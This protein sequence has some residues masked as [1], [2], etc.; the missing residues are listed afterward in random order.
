[1]TQTSPAA[2]RNPDAD[3]DS[4]PFW[5][6]LAVGRLLVPRCSSCSRSFF[7]PM[8]SCP[9]CASTSVALEESSGFGRVYS[10]VVTRTALD[11]TLAGEIPYAVVAVDLAE[12]SRML[13][14]FLG[15]AEL[16]EP[17]LE[18]VVAPYNSN[19]LTVPGFAP[20]R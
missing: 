7:P 14:R 19:G 15:D 4:Q 12:G 3:R 16:L 17:G 6:A 2:K 20:L 18:V 11:P 13:G 8:P 10:W 1:V 5:D 9:R